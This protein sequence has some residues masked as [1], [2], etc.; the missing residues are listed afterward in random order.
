MN[1]INRIQDYSVRFQRDMGQL[2]NFQKLQTKGS[3]FEDILKQEV[4]PTIQGKVSSSDVFLPKNI[5]EEISQDSYR[6]KLYDASVEFESMFVKLMLKEMKNS[7][8]KNK[9]IHGG[10]AEEIFED[11]LTDEQAKSISKNDSIGLAE[12]I[13]STLSQALPSLKA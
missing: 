12:Q 9:M 4:S 1:D 7:V 10:H 3:S 5:Q 8:Q 11:M 6:K 13:Y 2:Q